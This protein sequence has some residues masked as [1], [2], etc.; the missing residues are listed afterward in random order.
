MKSYGK[1]RATTASPERVWD[2]W[3][4]PNN[5]SA[6]NSGIKAAQ[7]EGPIHD[8]AAGT[9]TTSRGSRHT[10][11][12]SNVKPGRGYA[13]STSGPPGTTMTFSCAIEPNGSGS[14]ISQSVVLS[15]PMGFLF[16]PMLGPMM[17][18]HFV[19]VLDDLA[20]TAES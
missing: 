12:F 6:W 5:W 20:R 3:S 15:G 18:E 1:S 17:A 14:T 10:V 8:G 4:D 13:L 19:P 9:M 16:G 2:V 7:L 11:T